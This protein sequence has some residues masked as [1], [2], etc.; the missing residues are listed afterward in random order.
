MNQSYVIDHPNLLRRIYEIK[1]QQST[2][3]KI[4]FHNLGNTRAIAE[5]SG[6]QWEIKNNF[7]GNNISFTLLGTPA[8]SNLIHSSTINSKASFTIGEEEYYFKRTLLSKVRTEFV[9]TDKAGNELIKFTRRGAVILKFQ[10][11]I[12]PTKQTLDSNNLTSLIVIGFYL[13]KSK[14]YSLGGGGGSS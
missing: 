13:I 10:V 11:D 1:N 2:I 5:F 7:L 3:A 9:W 14:Y 8:S 12:L 4:S 6:Q